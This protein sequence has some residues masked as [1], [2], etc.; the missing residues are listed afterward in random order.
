M[1]Q[2]IYVYTCWCAWPLSEGAGGGGGQGTRRGN[3]STGGGHIEGSDP[4]SRPYQGASFESEYLGK[5]EA[6]LET[7]LA[8]YS[9]D[10]LGSLM[11]KLGKKS[12]ETTPLTAPIQPGTW[13]PR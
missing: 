6:I 9:G 12:R 3:I 5:F 7:G 11:N 1:C 13:L 4:L 8:Y 10:C 2:Y